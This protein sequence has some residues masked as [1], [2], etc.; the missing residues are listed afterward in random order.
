MRFKTCKNKGITL[1]ALIIT[2]IVMLI[3]V[4][5]TITVAMQGG[6]FD[7]ARGAAKDTQIQVDKEILQGA[8]VASYNPETEKV[9]KEKLIN[10]L[11]DWR[12]NGDG[13]YTCISPN[14]NEFTIDIN[15]SEAMSDIDLL[16]RYFLGED[17]SGRDIYEILDLNTMKFTN[18]ENE[19]IPNA[20]SS[21]RLLNAQVGEDI[22][23]NPTD[24]NELYMIM[25]YYIVYNNK[26]YRI[27]LH[28]SPLD[29]STI[30]QS[31][32]FIYEPKGREGDT[33][34]YSYNGTE[35]TDWKI[36]YDDGTN[37]EIVSPDV[38][39]NLTL[40]YGDTQ[41]TG[42]DNVDKSINS[43]NNA[44]NRLNEYCSSIVTNPNGKISVRSVGSNP[45]N[46]SDQQETRYSSEQLST[47]AGGKYNGKAKI[48]DLNYEQDIVRMSFHDVLVTE[49][50]YWIA[51]RAMYEQP[52]GV[53]L[54]VRV[55][56]NGI[57]HVFDNQGKICEITSDSSGYSKAYGVRPV[58]KLSSSN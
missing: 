44:V 23:G 7:T 47:F 51:S 11:S 50:S 31:V 9:E 40:G 57:T 24:I 38:I 5:V 6:L 53:S 4:G 48:D 19:V 8:V 28:Q 29:G 41:A 42:E 26:A 14:G 34:K 12:I 16:E 10:N 39:S 49:S 20:E 58:V 2:I 3:L 22:G 36:I 35:E 27:K 15:G 13:P 37:I 17:N 56:Y 25:N 1:I 46:P 18:N 32:T 30:T 33:I 52:G 45:S 54:Y 55:V 43:Y 21:I